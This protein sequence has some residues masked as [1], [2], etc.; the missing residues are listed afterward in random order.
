MRFAVL[1]NPG[2]GPRDYSRG[3]G[4]EQ[5]LRAL[6]AAQGVEAVISRAAGPELAERARRAVRSGAEVVV[7]GGGDGSVGAVAGTLAEAGRAA[8]GVLPLGTFNHFARDLGMP[9]GLEP[10]VQALARGRMRRVDLGQVNGRTFVNSS[11]LGLYPQALARRDSGPRRSGAGRLP[12]LLAA[13]AGALARYRLVRVRLV[14]DG[15]AFWRT[16]PCVLV[17]NNHIDFSLLDP[18]RAALD[19]GL[20]Y[21]YVAGRRSRWGTVLLAQRTLMGRLEQA[22]DLD[23]LA[24]SALR[25]ELEE[26]RV[27]VALDGEAW[28]LETPLVYRILPGAL[29]VLAP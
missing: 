12:A 26:P 29:R 10:A 11:S 5:R 27:G 6:F 23:L 14:A 25:L 8:L 16:T 15:Q 13:G 22:R 24:V 18:R 28:Q 4:L 7:V 20:L 9:L 21:V 1:L 19:E 17:G 2:A 3:T